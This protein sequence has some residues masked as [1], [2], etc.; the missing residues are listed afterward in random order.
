MQRALTRTVA[1]TEPAHEDSRLRGRTYS[2]PF[3]HVWQAAVTL[4][5]RGLPRWK[6]ISAD[7]HEGVVRA[8]AR[9]LVRKRVSDVTVSITLDENAQTRVDARSASREGRYDLGV[10]ARHLARFFKA[11][12]SRVEEA[13]RALA[14]RRRGPDAASGDARRSA[15]RGRGTSGGGPGDD[16]GGA[17]AA[18]ASE[19]SSD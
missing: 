9:S 16:V 19:R 5:D 3:E 14:R 6:L 17:A 10:N 18:G 12:D 13:R 8:K 7:D 2:V 11:L 15:A 1:A 4:A